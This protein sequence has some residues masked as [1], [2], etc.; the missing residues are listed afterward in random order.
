M[1]RRLVKRMIEKQKDV[2]ICFIDYSKAFDTVKHEPLIDLLQSLDIDSQDVKL[3]ANLYWN[4]EAA[5]RHNDEFSEA[6]S[7]SAGMPCVTP[8]TC[9][10]H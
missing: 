5:V 4:Q 3:L 9:F 6:I 7:S 10:I 8:S 1:L 2:Y